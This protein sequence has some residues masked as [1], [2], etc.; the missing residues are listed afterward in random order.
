M[1]HKLIAA[2]IAL[3]TSA[4]VHAQSGGMKGMD[5]KD[6]PM[7]GMD[8]KADRS[9]TKGSHKATGVATKVEKDKVTIKHGPVPTINWPSMTMAFTVK[10]RELMD[11]LSKDKKVDF[12]FRQEGRDYVVISV[13]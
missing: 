5:M 9:E 2:L 10:D 12:E 4:G 7:K 6:M 8:M 11:K 13:K 1:N 3:A